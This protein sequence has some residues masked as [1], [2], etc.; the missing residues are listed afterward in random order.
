MTINDV[1][2]SMSRGQ[3]LYVRVEGTIMTIYDH[4]HAA[5]NPSG[6]YMLELHRY[7]KSAFASTRDEPN[8]VCWRIYDGSKP[9]KW[10]PYLILSNI[11]RNSFVKAD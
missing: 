5:H 9:S 1:V 11:A 3:T 10:Y 7:L 4:Y 2:I 6:G 8:E